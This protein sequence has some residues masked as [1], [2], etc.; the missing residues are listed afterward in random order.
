MSMKKTLQNVINRPRG[1]GNVNHAPSFIGILVVLVGVLSTFLFADRLEQ[2]SVSDFQTETARRTSTL[3]NYISS[4]TDDFGQQLLSLAAYYHS[5][6]AITE[7]SWK[8]FIDRSQFVERHPHVLGVGFVDVILPSNLDEYIKNQKFDNPNFN[9]NPIGDRD[10]YTSIRYL[11]PHTTFNNRALGYDMYS[12]SVR[13]NSMSIARDEAKITMT[14]PV[15]L[16]QD[17]D[18]GLL[19]VL[20]YMPIYETAA[21]PSTEQLRRELLKG[22]VYLAVRPVDLIESAAKSSVDFGSISYSVQDKQTKLTMVE[23]K[24]QP[25]DTD[26]LYNNEQTIQVVDKEWVIKGEAYQPV[27]QRWTAPGVTFLLGIVTSFALGGMIMYVMTRRIERIDK[28]HE[29]EIQRTK[30]EL[31][32]LASHQLRTPATGVKQYVG[33]LLEGFVGEL[34]PEQS[35]IVRKAYEANERQLETINQILHVAK[36]DADQLVL[37]KNVINLSKLVKSVIDSMRHDS[38]THNSKIVFHVR[39]AVKVEADESYMRMV[40]E[41]LISNAL[42]YSKPGAGVTV[43]VTDTGGVA[44]VSVKDFGVGIDPKDHNKLF[45]KFSRIS[46]PLSRTVS[47]TG[48]GL[49]LSKQIMVS[50]GG[51]IEFKSIVGRGSTF[52]AIMPLYYPKKIKQNRRRGNNEKEITDS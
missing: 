16:R 14:S 25:L 11:E 40:I 30:N 46:N 27:L 8:D 34:N 4:Q 17:T 35:N 24:I 52:T 37:D 19:G 39:H 47:G 3:T 50:H 36:A 43:R 20:F 15:H 2:Q 45:E 7:Q 12:E 21:T 29:V 18:S 13:R 48:L 41:N 32:A 1:L 49:F 51:D 44:K 28:L 42:K 9:F 22:Y 31:L 33:L 5:G 38:D 26:T 23:K 6:G 10:L